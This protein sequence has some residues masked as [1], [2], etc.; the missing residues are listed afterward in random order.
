MNTYKLNRPA[1]SYTR[2][3]VMAAAWGLYA[4]QVHAVCTPSQ[5]CPTFS[6]IDRRY[7]YNNE[8]LT[9]FRRIWNAD[10]LRADRD[11]VR[12]RRK[13]AAWPRIDEPQGIKNNHLVKDYYLHR[14]EVRTIDKMHIDFF[15]R[16]H[17]ARNERDSKILTILARNFSRYQESRTA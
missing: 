10:R 5:N 15:C 7:N 16:N 8:V 1:N 6:G 2:R 11:K 17:W 4:T 12:D 13:G 14:S 3:D 9:E